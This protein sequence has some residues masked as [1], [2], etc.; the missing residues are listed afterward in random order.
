MKKEAKYESYARFVDGQKRILDD[1]CSVTS[2]NDNMPTTIVE[3]E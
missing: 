1:T 3:I 2:I